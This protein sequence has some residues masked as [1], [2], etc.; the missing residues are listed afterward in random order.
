MVYQWLVCL[1]NNKS[2]Q[3]IVCGNT[4]C[5]IAFLLVYSASYKYE[6]VFVCAITILLKYMKDLL[7]LT[8]TI[9]ARN[10]VEIQIK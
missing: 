4:L 8:L 7:K 1:H 2:V 10:K 9:P 3:Y 6:D 5:R